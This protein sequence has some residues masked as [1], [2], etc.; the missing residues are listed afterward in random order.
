MRKSKQKVIII[1]NQDFDITNIDL[2]IITMCQTNQ[3]KWQE[4]KEIGYDKP[5]KFLLGDHICNN[6]P[7]ISWGR[8]LNLTYDEL[9]KTIFNAGAARKLGLKSG[10]HKGSSI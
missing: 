1:N 5:F 6:Q 7:C 10:V 8:S 3:I 4:M 9:L 2:P